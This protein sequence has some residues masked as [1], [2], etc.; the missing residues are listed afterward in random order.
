[1]EDVNADGDSHRLSS[2]LF[3]LEA[4]AIL[5]FDPYLILYLNLLLWQGSSWG[6]TK[7]SEGSAL[8]VLKNKD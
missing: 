3:P 7:L 6:G 4:V 1:M 2:P 5:A 8:L